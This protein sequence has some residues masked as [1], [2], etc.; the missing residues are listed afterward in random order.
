M[1]EHIENLLALL[2]LEKEEE[3]EFYRK[4]IQRLSLEERKAEGYCWYPVKL[5]QQGYT[6]GDRA[7]VVVERPAENRKEHFFR[8]GKTVNFFTRKEGARRAEFAGVVH[9]VD[10]NKMKIILNSQDLPDWSDEGLT[11]VD[12]LF[13][14]RSYAEMEKALRQ[15]ME[16][17]KGRLAELR[18][19]LAGSKEPEFGQTPDIQHIPGL[20]ASQTAAIR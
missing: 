20:N 10:K 17:K 14:E 4:K 16:V 3:L 19:V 1:H 8:E 13:D 12:L 18:A 2:R 5:A 6:I 15:L 11:G 7:F 9:F